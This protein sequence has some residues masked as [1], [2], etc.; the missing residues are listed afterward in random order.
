M[1]RKSVSLLPEE[2]VLLEEVKRPSRK[3]RNDDIHFEGDQQ[4]LHAHF[5]SHRKL[6]GEH[7]GSC[8]I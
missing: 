1:V 6:I 8:A 4:D 5:S 2:L 3:L 7:K